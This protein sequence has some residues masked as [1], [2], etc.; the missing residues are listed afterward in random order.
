MENIEH[1][2]IVYSNHFEFNGHILA[3]RKKLLFNIG[4][5]APNYLP[6][7][8]NG[9]S[10]GWII[11]R[12]WLSITKAK[13][14]ASKMIPKEVDVSDLNWATQIEIDECFNLEKK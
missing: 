7:K 14:L 4:G 13:E 2:K 1:Y 6:I 9:S 11:N 8:E 3:F 12:K 10:K 5:V